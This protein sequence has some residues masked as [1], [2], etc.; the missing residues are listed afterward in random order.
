MVVDVA[1]VLDVAF[2]LDVVCVVVVV[3]WCVWFL[4]R[5]VNEAL[6]Q[7]PWTSSARRLVCQAP[8]CGRCTRTPSGRSSVPT[9]STH[10]TPSAGMSG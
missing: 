9:H 5:V 6:Q 1:Y 7:A 2:V 4:Q 3:V 10:Q 8:P